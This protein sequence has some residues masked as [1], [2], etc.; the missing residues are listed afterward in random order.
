MIGIGKRKKG[1]VAQVPKGPERSSDLSDHGWLDTQ[2]SYLVGRLLDVGIDG[3]GPF[4]SAAEVASAALKR[5]AGDVERAVTKIVSSHL[6]LAGVNGFLTSLGGFFTMPVSLPVNVAGFYVLATR[7]TA[8]IAI[9][10]GYDIDSPQVR[11]AVL[12]AL[13]G[14]DA[15]DLLGKA[16]L[17]A[18]G[19]TLGN[20]ASS[21]LPA[22]ALMVLN[23]AVGFHVITTAGRQ[24]LARFGRAVPVVGGALGGGLDAWLSQRIAVNARSE[25]PLIGQVAAGPF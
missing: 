23:K 25:F 13:V 1:E 21:R 9:V 8:A 24:T 18:P 5:S 2:S 4:D 15:K 11:S 6:R 3:R 20:L 19:G 17:T 22:P 7:M 10:R 16:G 14:A 12:L